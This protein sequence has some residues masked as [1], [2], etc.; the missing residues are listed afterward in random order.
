MVDNHGR[1]LGGHLGSVET[2]A[3]YLPRIQEPPEGSSMI[4]TIREPSDMC[5]PS[6]E[7]EPSN[8]GIKP[9]TVLPHTNTSASRFERERIGCERFSMEVG[10]EGGRNCEVYPSILLLVLVGVIHLIFPGLNQY[11]CILG[12]LRDLLQG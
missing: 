11:R 5:P 10:R 4:E 9:Y 3:Q 1:T 12:I 8:N 6:T 7:E 2:P